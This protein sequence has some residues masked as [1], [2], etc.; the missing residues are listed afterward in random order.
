MVKV[1]VHGFINVD[2]VGLVD[3]FSEIDQEMECSDLQVTPGGSAAN[4]AVGLSRLGE[5]VYFLG[6]I[7][8]DS[9]TT[10]LLESFEKVKLDYIQ[11]V[12]G[13]TSGTVMVLVNNAG[14]RT[15]YTYPGANS[16]YNPD[17]VPEKFNESI[18]LLHLSSP[19]L[20]LAPTFFQ[21]KERCPRLRISFDPSTLLTKRGLTYLLPF[22][23]KTDILFVNRSELNDLFPDHDIDYSIKALHDLGINQIFVKLGSK[24]ALSS[25]ITA[26]SQNQLVLPSLKVNSIDSTGAG[27]AFAV[28]ALFGIIREWPQE[29]ILRTAIKL[30][31][32]AVSQTGARKGLPYSL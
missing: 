8:E 29:A 23:S 11:T 6:A 4:V 17:L 7:G 22:L 25:F 1:A 18:G 31:A 28:G 27:D 19:L 15:M 26:G 16:D 9:Y 2:L 5:E 20:S 3:Q 14:L 30:G 24:G 10:F 12:Q 21:W 13:K 32:C